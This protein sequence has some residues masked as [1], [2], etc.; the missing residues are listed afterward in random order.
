MLA[1]SLQHRANLNPTPASSS[2]F[3]SPPLLPSQ[4]PLSHQSP[5]LSPSAAIAADTP[6]VSVTLL[7]GH[8]GQSHTLS[9]PASTAL[10]SL[11]PHLNSC[12]GVSLFTTSESSLLLLADGTDVSSPAVASLS[13]SELLAGH[14]AAAG[15]TVTIYSYS[16][17]LLHQSSSAESPS[18]T[19]PTTLSLPLP[20]SSIPLA[21][22]PPTAPLTH[23]AEPPA[24]PKISASPSVAL[25]SLPDY[26]RIFNQQLTTITAA[27]EHIDHIVHS[28]HSSLHQ[29]TTI[30][31][32]LTPIHAYTTS[33]LTQLLKS[34][35]PLQQQWQSVSDNQQSALDNF[36]STIAGLATIP[37]PVSLSGATLLECIN[38]RTYRD[39]I[40]KLTHEKSKTDMKYNDMKH[41]LEQLTTILHSLRPYLPK[42]YEQD[43]SI[44]VVLDGWKQRQRNEC[45]K[46]MNQIINLRDEA[47]HYCQQMESRL[48][49]TTTTIT[50][51]A[52]V[53]LEREARVKQMEMEGWN[54]RNKEEKEQPIIQQ[55]CAVYQHAATQ[56]LSLSTSLSTHH[57]A[58]LVSCFS[59]LSSLSSLSASLPLYRRLL[60]HS[61]DSFIPL[62]R[63]S[64]LS[65]SYS[66]SL[67]ELRRRQ[68]RRT[69]RGKLIATVVD[70]WRSEER[71]EYER[72]VQWWQQR[73]INLPSGV[74]SLLGLKAVESG[75]V[76][77]EVCDWDSMLPVVTAEEAR[78]V[79]QLIE[80]GSKAMEERK[81]EAE[82]EDDDDEQKEE[83]MEEKL[84][85][86]EAENA[87]LQTQ[88]RQ[89]QQQ[90]HQPTI[91][92]SPTQPI[93]PL[94]AA[95]AG[96]EELSALRLE[97]DRRQA[98]LNDAN[99]TN[100]WLEE[101]LYKREEE[102]N[103]ERTRRDKS[104]RDSREV[105]MKLVAT[106]KER[107]RDRVRFEAVERERVQWYERC[108]ERV[109]LLQPAVNDLVM[110]VRIAVAG[111]DVDG[112]ASSGTGSGGG[113]VAVYRVRLV[114]D[115]SRPM[116]LSAE[117]MSVLRERRTG[118]G[119]GVWPEWV[120][121]HVVELVGKRATGSVREMEAGLKLNDEYWMAT[122][123]LVDFA[124]QQSSEQVGEPERISSTTNISNSS[125]SSSSNSTQSSSTICSSSSSTASTASSPLS[126][127]LDAMVLAAP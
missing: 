68:Q 113:A 41:T 125:S 69:K 79:R 16:R 26:I 7:N 70:R 73:G 18:P 65:L 53:E 97:V 71:D 66:H 4:P 116:F 74:Q 13:L 99:K 88:L 115:G 38:E 107:T 27:I 94:P 62:L 35:K 32:A 45:V 114:G 5:A 52:L 105:A 23:T 78:R 100:A 76:K 72:R 111:V 14:A 20:L 89:Q 108:N 118:T 30:D 60:S 85:R 42:Q 55:H 77:V 122:V 104:E 12:A 75:W 47:T 31:A 57:N 86:L 43:D 2:S 81:E 48:T 46:W 95:A 3:P 51:A 49:L 15:Q 64:R 11:A 40:E 119:G 24:Y 112:G 59:A 17:E 29:L 124:E 83:T 106:V 21:F 80:G 91:T 33:I 101:E 44:S 9:V 92:T 87:T 50:T 56:L 1:A 102:L 37:L 96:S 103:H 61:V 123:A 63:L 127:A 25:R 98:L 8:T 6:L 22:T 84:K 110:A 34:T 10:A 126:P 67:Q 58:S 19:P 36:E 39:N 121:G 109:T 93:P 28:T 54:R 90:Q 117:T 120:V 82:E